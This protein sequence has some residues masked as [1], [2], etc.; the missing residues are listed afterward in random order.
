MLAHKLRPTSKLQQFSD[1]R[2]LFVPSTVRM[3][4]S[5]YNVILTS[6]QSE[7]KLKMADRLEHQQKMCYT[8]VIVA[9]QLSLNH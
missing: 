2:I 1:D 4:I 6:S 7:L 5:I 8:Q 3:T 9:L